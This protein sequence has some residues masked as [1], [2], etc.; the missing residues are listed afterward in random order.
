M[1]LI[2]TLADLPASVV[3]IHVF[4]YLSLAALGRLDAAV[5]HKG[6]R[7]AVLEAFS[8]VRTVVFPRR[9]FNCTAWQEKQI[10]RWC[11]N[12]EVTIDKI[13]FSGVRNEDG[14]CLLEKVLLRVPPDGTVR[15]QYDRNGKF[16]DSFRVLCSDMVRSRITSLD[17]PTTLLS[18][19][20]CSDMRSIKT[21]ILTGECYAQFGGSIPP[22]EQALRQLLTGIS[23][24][25]QLMFNSMSRLCL[26]TVRALCGHGA[27]LTHMFFQDSNGHHELLH[28]IGQH[29]RNLK[30]LNVV[31][32]NPAHSSPNPPWYNEQGWIAVAQ[33]CR[34][35]TSVNLTFG[36]PLPEAVLMAFAEHC[37]QLKTLWLA[38]CM[39]E[40]TD[41]VL[42]ALA[43]GCPKL[44]AFTWYTW[45]VESLS[46]VDAAQSLLSRLESFEF[47]CCSDTSPAILARTVSYLRSAKTLSIG[48]LSPAY[49]NALGDVTL[50]LEKCHTLV[51]SGRSTKR[52]GAVDGF[53]VAVA[54]GSPRLHM[55]ELKHG[56]SISG[57]ALVRAAALSPNMQRVK[58]IDCAI[59]DVSEE[60]LVS[61]ARSWPKL[62]QLNIGGNLAFTDSVVRTLAHTCPRLDVL[63]LSGSTEL[64]EEGLIEAANVLPR[65]SLMVPKKFN[66]A[67]CDRVK[68]AVAR[69]RADA[70]RLREARSPG[71]TRCGPQPVSSGLQG[72]CDA[73]QPHNAAREWSSL[74]VPSTNK[75]GGVP[76]SESDEQAALSETG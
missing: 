5:A 53:V 39:A 72:V 62:K 70:R 9:S 68:Q 65:C 48:W 44:H 13:Q 28:L 16:E 7:V 19:L 38:G 2:D 18:R 49:T 30:T 71:Q 29:C 17:I 69:A 61:V 76:T 20:K 50:T 10:W 25:E 32:G 45:T 60:E 51:L 52:V 24:L 58:C 12:R 47:E 41:A 3:G 6:H 56:I 66:S 59:V 54:A 63:N 34:Q 40:I 67:E 42:L 27:S 64:T 15:C 21:L 31:Y 36:A 74:C 1:A 35:L 8:Y 55:V 75:I 4:G 43:A 11:V 37:P 22:L 26:E 73:S 57:P 33:G 46:T 23:A 14:V